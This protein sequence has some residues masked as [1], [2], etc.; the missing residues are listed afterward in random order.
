[1]NPDVVTEID[2]AMAHVRR[3]LSQLSAASA[4]LWARGVYGSQQ[5]GRMAEALE[6]ICLAMLSADNPGVDGV[7]IVWEVGGDAEDTGMLWWRVEG[8]RGGRKQH[9]F[10]PESESYYDYRGSEWY[11][12]AQ[13]AE[14]LAIVGPYIDA[15][16]TDDHALTA[17][18]ALV[19]DGQFIGVAAADLNVSTMTAVLARVLGR[20][21]D[22]VLVDPEDRVVASNFALLT[23]GLLLQPF[24][25]RGDMFIAERI[26]TPVNGWHLVRLGKKSHA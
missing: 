1:M 14:G 25:R 3:V 16:G 2:T 24:L 13:A 11:R 22:L 15:W 12:A 19:V 8:G 4:E 26:S 20:F 23:P 17:S 10:N 6:P 9:V 5:V 18:M 21:D 7:G